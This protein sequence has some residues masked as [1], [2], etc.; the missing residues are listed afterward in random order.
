MATVAKRYD[1]D[2]AWRAAGEPCG[3]VGLLPQRREDE[4]STGIGW[5]QAANC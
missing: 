4:E 1:L 5:A 3:S 2:Y